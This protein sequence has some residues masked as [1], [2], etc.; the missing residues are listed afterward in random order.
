MVHP[1][2]FC[3]QLPLELCVEPVWLQLRMILQW[4]RGRRCRTTEDFL[5][6]RK[7]SA[8]RDHVAALG[9]LSI[10]SRASQTACLK[11]GSDRGKGVKA[12]KQVSPEIAQE[13]EA[14]CASNSMCYDR[15]RHIHDTLS[16]PLFKSVNTG[17]CCPA[18][19]HVARKRCKKAAVRGGVLP[20]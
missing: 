3:S 9:F 19:L 8:S 1:A 15:W 18:S 7:P 2:P 6:I 11:W 20:V 13:A 10:C 5:Q 17:V 4:I 16:R 14:R 12:G